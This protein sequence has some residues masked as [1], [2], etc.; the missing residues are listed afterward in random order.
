MFLRAALM[1][2][3]FLGVVAV[4][5]GAFVVGYSTLRPRAEYPAQTLALLWAFMSALAWGLS[6][7]GSL[8]WW[9]LG[10]VS[11]MRWKS[12]FNLFAAGFAALAVGYSTP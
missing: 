2:G 12:W 6:V 9:S 11:G 5:T 8:F 10:L 4:I 3:A 7:V 1:L